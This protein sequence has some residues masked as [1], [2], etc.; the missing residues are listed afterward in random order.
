MGPELLFLRLSATLERRSW[1]RFVSR[2][3]A[4]T[5]SASA[6]FAAM[7]TRPTASVSASETKTNGGVITTSPST[8]GSRTTRQPHMAMSKASEVADDHRLATATFRGRTRSTRRPIHD[9]EVWE[10]A[11]SL[12]LL[13]HHA[14]VRPERRRHVGRGQ[15][16]TVTSV[17]APGNHMAIS[18]PTWL[19]IHVSESWRRFDLPVWG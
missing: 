7:M 10:L 3:M 8:A 15:A 14:A 12:S 18:D 17:R 9:V 6:A 11:A 1:L 2:W 19:T 4:N 5:A 16:R 13:T